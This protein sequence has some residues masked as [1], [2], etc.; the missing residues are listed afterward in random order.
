MHILLDGTKDTYEIPPAIVDRMLHSQ[1]T[2]TYPYFSIKEARGSG[3]LTN[4]IG[5]ANI[6]YSGIFLS[7]VGFGYL[8]SYFP[9]DSNK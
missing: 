4:G 6:N 3:T 2:C 5:Y 7:D 8:S 9:I 1:I